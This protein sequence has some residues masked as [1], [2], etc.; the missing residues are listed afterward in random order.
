MNLAEWRR[1]TAR[2]VP[3][4]GGRRPALIS[5]RRRACGPPAS[6]GGPARRCIAWTR[7]AWNH[8]SSG[9]EIGPVGAQKQAP[10]C[11]IADR[12]GGARVVSGMRRSIRGSPERPVS[13][14]S[15]PP[16]SPL[17]RGRCPL[18][19]SVEPRMAR[20][21]TARSWRSRHGRCARFSAIWRSGRARRSIEASSPSSFGASAA[22]N[23]PGRACGRRPRS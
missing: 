15:L 10:D 7:C 22:R 18:A 13:R 4:D 2:A 17:C 16:A 12:R 14:E 21:R 6:T 9:I 8:R 5:N 3:P 23:R 19:S 1:C 20:S 11:A